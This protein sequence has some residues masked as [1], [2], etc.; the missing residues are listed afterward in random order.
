[1]GR[2]IRREVVGFRCE[3]RSCE[4]VAV[5]Q[6]LPVGAPMRSQEQQWLGLLQRGWSV[7]LTPQIRSY[8][9][10]HEARVW[11][12]SCRTNPDRVHLCV[13]HSVE[14]ASLVR[15]AQRGNFEAAA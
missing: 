9:P 8:C 10:R 6:P 3:L 7:V 4:Q 12:C 5:V 1:M 13:V 2:I 14:A 15:T 11:E